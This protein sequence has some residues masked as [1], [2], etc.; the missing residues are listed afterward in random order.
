M[1]TNLQEFLYYLDADTTWDAGLIMYHEYECGP[2]LA[3]VEIGGDALHSDS[4]GARSLTACD[5]VQVGS[6]VEGSD[7]EVTRA[8]LWFPFT[9]ELFEAY[10]KDINDEACQLW[11]E[12]NELTEESTPSIRKELNKYAL[13]Y[14]LSNLG[15]PGVM[16]DLKGYAPNSTRE[17]IESEL[18][19]MINEIN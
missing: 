2:W 6:I 1:I 16:K 7:A 12:A 13:T 14:L 3:F 8:P 9:P 4:E 5:G 11:D 18:W 19:G 10:V 15:A 17:G